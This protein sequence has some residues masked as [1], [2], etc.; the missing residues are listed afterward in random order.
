MKRNHTE[1]LK[2]YISKNA[3]LSFKNNK[4]LKL[5]HHKEI[6]DIFY[7]LIKNNKILDLI[8]EEK[9][10]NESMALISPFKKEDNKEVIA[11]CKNILNKAHIIKF[12]VF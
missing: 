1:C 6:D 11:L 5:A 12:K 10:I 3:D 4:L 9:E 8:K 2:V 7:L